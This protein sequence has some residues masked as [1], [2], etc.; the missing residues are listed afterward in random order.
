VERLNLKTLQNPWALIDGFSRDCKLRGMTEE[1]IR[2]YVSS[3]KIFMNFLKVRGLGVYEV[4]AHVLKDFLQHV[5]Y[6]R[7]PS[8]RQLRTIFRR[9]Q[10]SMIT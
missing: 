6:E 7:K 9:F 4:D 3:L 8:V 1:S 5:V 10:P 2:R